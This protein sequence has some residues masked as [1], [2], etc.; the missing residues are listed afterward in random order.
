MYP[1]VKAAVGAAAIPV[2]RIQQAGGRVEHDPTWR[3]WYHGSVF[4][5]SGSIKKKIYKAASE[6]IE[7]D[8]AEAA[9]LHALWDSGNSQQLT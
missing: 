4:E 7:I 2:G 6:I 5:I 3:N 1:A 8:Q 9:R